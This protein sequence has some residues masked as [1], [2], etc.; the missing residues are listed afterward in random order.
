M[1]GVHKAPKNRCIKHGKWGQFTYTIKK[2]LKNLAK[3][4]IL[5]KMCVAISAKRAVYMPKLLQL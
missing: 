2:C 4:G 3:S 1:K 5:K